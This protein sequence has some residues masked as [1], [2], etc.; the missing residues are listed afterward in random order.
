MPKYEFTFFCAAHGTIIIDAAVQDA[1]E[2][3]LDA[4]TYDEI[5][6]YDGNYGKPYSIPFEFELLESKVD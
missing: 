1:A 3:L 4:M 5:F 6:A 2:D